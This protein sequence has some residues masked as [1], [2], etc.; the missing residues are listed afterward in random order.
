MP[1]QA[2]SA[3]NEAACAW[4]GA[5]RL[6]TN[7]LCYLCCSSRVCSAQHHDVCKLCHLQPSALLCACTGCER[8]ATIT[9]W[10]DW[11]HR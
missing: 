3:G 2:N 7:L 1:M 11:P 4:H 8:L 9:L 5:Y 10:I 6:A